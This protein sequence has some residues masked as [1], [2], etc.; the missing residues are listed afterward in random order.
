MRWSRGDRNRGRCGGNRR[1]GCDGRRSPDSAGWSRIDHK[2]RTGDN[3]RL[4]RRRRGWSLGRLHGAYCGD[5]RFRGRDIVRAALVHS[6]N[7][8]FLLLEPSDE[9]LKHPD[10][11]ADLGDGVG[12]DTML[13][14]LLEF[15]RLIT[16]D[17]PN[18]ISDLHLGPRL[19][20]VTIREPVLF[21]V[22]NLGDPFSQFLDALVNLRNRETNLM[23]VSTMFVGLA[24]RHRYSSAPSTNTFNDECLGEVH[25]DEARAGYCQEKSSPTSVSW[26]ANRGFSNSRKSVIRLAIG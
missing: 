11:S 3:C 16:E 9:L 8:K 20:C 25:S 5:A 10:G 4:R 24:L 12:F 7:V 15:R 1:T 2:G 17:P 26:Q 14:K 21:Q 23:S 13:S 22:F 18:G 19:Q 6:Q